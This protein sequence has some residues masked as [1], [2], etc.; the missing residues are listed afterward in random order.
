MDFFVIGIVGLLRYE[1]EMT[2]AAKQQQMELLSLKDQ[3][4]TNVHHELRSPLIA[5]LGFL[6]ILRDSDDTLSK[7]DRTI[8]IELIQSDLERAMRYA[9]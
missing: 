2:E 3:F 1:L 9:A 4:S 8:F 6:D 7:E 5:I